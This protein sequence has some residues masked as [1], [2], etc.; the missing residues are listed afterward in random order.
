[1]SDNTGYT[2]QYVYNSLGQLSEVEDGQGKMLVLYSYDAV[3]RLAGETMSNGTSTTYAYDADGYE[4]NVTN[5]GV[6][7]TVLSTFSYTYNNQGQRQ[8]DHR[9]RY[10][11][12]RL[13][14]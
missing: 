13:R 14:H 8:H 11:H 2:E 7:G 10:D 1:M 4:T 3:G 9:N 5:F 6:G 12:I